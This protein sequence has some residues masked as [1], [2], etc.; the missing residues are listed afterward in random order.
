VALLQ[1][2]EPGAEPASGDDRAVGESCTRDDVQ[3]GE[4]SPTA[5]GSG[6]DTWVV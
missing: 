3:D 2:L 5:A 4:A 6:S 1:L